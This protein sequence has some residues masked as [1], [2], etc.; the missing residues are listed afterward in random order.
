MMNRKLLSLTIAIMWLTGCSVAN[1]PGTYAKSDESEVKR[2]TPQ[3]LQ[4]KNV[5]APSAKAVKPPVADVPTSN[6]QVNEPSPKPQ[7]T[8]DWSKPEKVKG[9]DEKIRGIVT[10]ALADI[11]PENAPPQDIPPKID[12]P[13]S[14][15]QQYRRKRLQDVMVGARPPKDSPGDTYIAELN[16]EGSTTVVIDEESARLPAVVAPRSRTG[17]SV[18]KPV[19]NEDFL[20]YTVQSGDSLWAIAEYFYGD[21]FRYTDVFEANRDLIE[22]T[23]FLNI[24]QPLRI[25]KAG[26]IRG[27]S[28]F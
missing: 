21:G 17:R 19:S 3:N 10:R 8:V 28:T 22:Q 15:Q 20:V 2:D 24:G 27:R 9:R 6:D 18:T 26:T 7:K 12:E 14:T 4:Q 23:N 25:P 11:P 1:E 13:T 5:E 16:E